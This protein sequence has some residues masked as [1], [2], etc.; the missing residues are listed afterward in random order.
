MGAAALLAVLSSA[1]FGVS[2]VLSAA[3]VRRH[4]PA[5]LALWAQLLGLVL[6]A[7]LTVAVRPAAAPTT[8]AWGAAAGA[9]GALAILA[10]YTALQHGSTAVV[11]SVAGCGVLVPVA[12]GLLRGEAIS[13]RAG[14]GV[15][16]ATCG[17]LLV[18]GTTG[19]SGPA[20][21]RSRDGEAQRASAGPPPVPAGARPVPAADGCLSGPARGSPQRASLRLAVL[22]ALGLGIFFV[23][24]ERATAAAG[25]EAGDFATAVVVALSVQVG[26]LVVTAAAATRHTRRCLGLRRSLLVPAAA[27]GALDLGADLLLNLAVGRGPLAVVGPLGSLAPVV[28]VLLATVV[29]RQ[30]LPRAQAAGIAAV[31]SGVVL[32]GSG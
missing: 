19:G 10:F 16:I 20:D 8:V 29:L 7:G 24:L 3:A 1:A 15:V 27:V 2:D 17:V 21:S 18:A 9:V 25:D 11:T 22:S 23:V 6:I 31:L 30:R 26:A 14:A 12:A 5:A 4:A 13:W 32:V 28:A